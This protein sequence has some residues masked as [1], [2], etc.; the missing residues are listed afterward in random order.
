MCRGVLDW[1]NTTLRNC[2]ITPSLFCCGILNVCLGGWWQLLH[3]QQRSSVQA[4]FCMDASPVQD[5]LQQ[6]H[7]LGGVRQGSR[8]NGSSHVQ[9]SHSYSV[10]QVKVAVLDR[11][12]LGSKRVQSHLVSWT[13]FAPCAKPLWIRLHIGWKNTCRKQS[14]ISRK[15]HWG[16]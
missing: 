8:L 7:F 14:I 13:R 9:C 4:V 11:I 2:L 5:C 3:Q 12:S 6:L 15:M 1:G 16:H 10:R